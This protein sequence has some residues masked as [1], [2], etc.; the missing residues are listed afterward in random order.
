[1][2]VASAGREARERRE[3]PLEAQPAARGRARARA[4]RR[5]QA[6]D[7]CSR[8]HLATVL[9]RRRPAHSACRPDPSEVR[10]CPLTVRRARPAVRDLANYP[11]TSAEGSGVFTLRA[12]SSTLAREPSPP[13]HER[14]EDGEVDAKCGVDRLHSGPAVSIRPPVRR[15]KELWKWW[16]L[17]TSASDSRYYE[18]PSCGRLVFGCSSRYA[19][20]G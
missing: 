17:W 3:P 6:R 2:V 10:R 20:I 11:A 1:V 14:H 13:A 8:V 19:A 15:R 9:L 7:L 18:R 5:A 12:R 4:A 16:N